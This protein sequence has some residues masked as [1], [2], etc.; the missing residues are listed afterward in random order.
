VDGAKISD[1]IIIIIIIIIIVFTIIFLV[2]I[3]GTASQWKNST[4][5][6][7]W[8]LGDDT[9][10]NKHIPGMSCLVLPQSQRLQQLPA[11]NRKVMKLENSRKDLWWHH[12]IAENFS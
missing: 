12:R 5:K 11:T 1:I 4:A 2:I 9:T 6:V 3:T 10:E 8:Q 7:K